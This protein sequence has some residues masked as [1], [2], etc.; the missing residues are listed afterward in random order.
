MT[1]STVL[2]KGLEQIVKGLESEAPKRAIHDNLTDVTLKVEAKAKKSTVVDTGRLRASITHKIGEQSAI[3]GTNVNYAGFIE[4]GTS[5]M[6]ARHMEGSTKVL[7]V[8]MFAHTV[9][10]I[11][12]EIEGYEL[13]VVRQVEQEAIGE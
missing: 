7:G 2:I 10:T 4:Y 12:P 8:G 13:K 11:Q 5:K 6:K 1:E 3:I 9:N